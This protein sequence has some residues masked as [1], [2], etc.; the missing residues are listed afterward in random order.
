MEI[1]A[2]LVKELR[3]RTGVSMG[4]CKK[5]LI[6][7]NGDIEAAIDFLRKKG[8]SAAAKKAGRIAA[9]GLVGSYIHM[10]GRI[11]VLV[12]V[13]CETDFVAN[14]PD[15]KELVKDIAMQIAASS[16]QWVSR[17]EVPEE[18]VERERKVLMELTMAEGKPENI[19]AKIVE[20]RLDK[21]YKENCLLDQMYIKN[22]EITV[23]QL[24]T[25]KIAQM[26]ENISIRRF[27]RFERGEGI[28]KKQ[29]NFADEVAAQ[30]K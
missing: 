6:E 3:E 16:P 29:E 22:T 4:E 13:N 9:E 30:L 2:T 26:G 7:C 25:E 28:E 24:I 12:E 27:A 19:A 21:F 1:T 15:F 14:T 8:L 18:S 20:G 5:A 10:G 11:G 23:K 17:E